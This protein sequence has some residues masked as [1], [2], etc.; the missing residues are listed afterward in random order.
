MLWESLKFVRG[1]DSIYHIKKKISN[2]LSGA[3]SFTEMG[4]MEKMLH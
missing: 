2:F 3:M 1:G 4:R